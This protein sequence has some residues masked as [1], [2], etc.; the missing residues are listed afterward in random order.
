MSH[1]APS[2]AAADVHELVEPR[3]HVCIPGDAVLSLGPKGVV[4]V[5][6]GLSTIYYKDQRT[7]VSRALVMS[8]V[9]AALQK[10]PHS[11]SSVS[12]YFLES[13]RTRRYFCS[14]GDPVVGIVIRK[15]PPHF[16]HIYIGGTALIYMDALAF[17]GATKTSHP[18]LTEGT[19]VYGF[20]KSRSA[21]DGEEVDDELL[22]GA[23]DVNVELSCAASQLGLAPKEW[24]SGEAI[25]GP[26]YDGR[27][28][29]LPLSYVRSMLAPLPEDGAPIGEKRARNDVDGSAEEEM[30]ASFL[31]SLLGSRVPFE[32]CVG[33]NGIVWV[34]G[35]SSDQD[36]SLGV[37]RTIAVCACIMEGQG[38]ATR[39]D[40]ESRVEKYFPS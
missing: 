9:C 38:D 36:P 2:E 32:I 28:L 27:I 17:D 10:E 26:L 13:P 5:G 12:R 16:Y 21:T 40:I 4:A 31:I 22:V 20:V 14:S 24:T 3:R 8:N 11:S 7:G 19:I 25:F 29:H 39:G 18:R 15:M 33:M 35:Q 34:K 37:K 30:P 6:S 1:A 23:D